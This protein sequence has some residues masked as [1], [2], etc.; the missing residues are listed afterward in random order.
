MRNWRELGE[1]P[2]SE[3][4][5]SSSDETNNDDLEEPELPEPEVAVAPAAPV[6]LPIETPGADADQDGTVDD[7]WD[8]PSSSPEFSRHH[9][10]SSIRKQPPPKPPPVEGQEEKAE[11]PIQNDSLEGEKSKIQNRDTTPQSSLSSLSSISSPPD[12]PILPQLSSSPTRWQPNP[13]PVQIPSTP[14]RLPSSHPP[15]PSSSPYPIPDAPRIPSSSPQPLEAPQ[16]T[17]VPEESP[18]RTAIRLE[19]S[20]RPRKPIQ[21]HP[22]LLENAKYATFMKSH[23]VKPIKVVQ[24]SQSTRETEEEDSQEQ[25]FQDEESQETP[26]V[27]FDNSDVDEL[28]LSPS[29]PKTSPGHNLRA[30]SQRTNGGSNTD[31]T[32]MSDGED[33]PDLHNLKPIS[34]KKRSRTLQSLKRPS[35]TQQL[36]S[37]RRKRPRVIPDD[38]SPIFPSRLAPPLITRSLPSSPLAREISQQDLETTRRSPTRRLSNTPSIAFF[39]VRRQETPIVIEDDESQDTPIFVQ[40]NKPEETPILQDDDHNESSDAESNPSGE[41][42]GSESEVV[43][44]HSRR[45]RGVLPASWL[46]L[47]QPAPK[48][49]VRQPRYTP[50][51]PEPIIR[52]GV[53]LPKPGTQRPPPSTAFLFDDSEESDGEPSGFQAASSTRP[54]STAPAT[55]ILID[56]DASSGMEDDMVDWMLPGRKRQSSNLTS[57]RSKKQKKTA[58][59]S[60]FKGR[61]GQ[62][63]RQ[64]KITSALSR[65]KSAATASTSRTR[66][67][68]KPRHSTTQSKRKRAVTPPLLS[69]LD[70]IEPDAPNFLKIAAR[71][72][73]KKKTMGK[74]SP[75][76]KIISLASRADNID[77]LSTLRAWKSGKTQPRVAPELSKRPTQPKKRPVMREVSKNVPSRAQPARPKQKTHS[78]ELLRQS[79]LESFVLVED[80]NDEV[81]QHSEA[82]PH[83]KPAIRKKPIQDR[84]PWMRPAQLEEDED[85]DKRRQLNA[86][87]RRL[88]AFYKRAQQVLNLPID[89][90]PRTRIDVDFTLQ[91]GSAHQNDA[92]TSLAPQ[93]STMTTRDKPRVAK[94]R[95]RKTRRPRHVDIE[96]PQ[97]LRANDPLPAEV[98]AV[99]V[100]D[101]KPDQPQDKLQGLGSYGTIYTQHF[102]V[103]PLDIGVFFHQS[104]VIGRGLV[105]KA[106][107]SS[108]TERLRHQ[109]A[110]VSWT[111]GEGVVFRWGVW[112][113][114]TSSELGILVDWIGEQ[115]S[116]T[117]A[118]SPMVGA[119]SPIEASDFI[120]CYILKS[121]SV[122]DELA[123]KAVVARCMEVFTSFTARFD[124]LEWKD[125]SVR[126]TT[127]RFE[128]ASRFNVAMLAV[129]SI[130]L[131]GSNPME[132]MKVE[133]V[134]T[135]LCRTTIK[136][137]LQSG[138]D[139]LREVY[140]D[141]QQ[142]SFRERGIRSDRVLVNCWVIVLRVLESVNIPRSS[143]W[144]VTQSVMLSNGA[145]SGL[146]MHT[147]EQLWQNMFTLLPLCEIDNAGILIPGLR[148]TAPM[149]GW[150]LP[151]RLL[152]RVFELYQRNPRQPASFNEYCRALVAR[153]HFLVQQWGWRKYTVILG[154]IFDFFGSQ[155]LANLRNE[156]VYKSPRFLEELGGGNPSLFIQPE[157]RC[158]HIFIKLLALAI[159]KL[160]ELGRVNDIK[161]LVARTLPNHNRQYHK[162]DTIHQHDLAALR[163]HHDLLCN[164]FWVSPP[165]LRP[166]VHL[167]EKLVVPASAHKEACLISIRAWS[168]LARFVISNGEGV[169][170]FRPFAVWRNNIFNQVLD[171]Y[172]SAE[173]DIEQQFRALAH[174]GFQGI[175]KEMRD[176]MIA[177]NKASALD[178]LA[179]SVKTS[180]VV[181]Q[182]APT[183]EA[184]MYGLNTTQLQKVFTS[185]DF[186]SQKFDWSILSVALDT[187]GNFVARIDQASEEQYSSEFLNNSQSVHSRTL[188]EAILMVNEQ[189]ARDFFW[190]SRTILSL[191]TPDS[192][193]EQNPQT[194]CVEKTITLA[195]KLA[196][197]FIKDRLTKL[198]S[199]FTPGKYS[200]F[201]SLPKDNLTGERKYLPLFLAHLLKNQIFDF[202]DIGTSLLGLWILSIIKPYSLLQYENFLGETLEHQNLPFI[203]SVSVIP[204]TSPDYTTNYH[205]FLSA[206]QYMRQ[207]LRSASSSTA[208]KSLREEYSSILTLCQTRIKSD[209]SSSLYSNTADY[210][211][212][213]QQLISLLKS[214]GVNIVTIDSFF[215]QP[216]RVYS[217]PMHDLTLH[218]AGIIAYGV[219]LSERDT[220]AGP[221][222]FWY[223][224]NSFKLAF[225]NGKLREEIK[226]LKKVLREEKNVRG[227]VMSKILPAV[228]MGVFMDGRGRGE[229][230]WLILEV[231]VWVLKGVL[232]EGIMPLE[233]RGE[234]EVEGIGLML[235]LVG[236]WLSRG[237][238]DLDENWVC[239]LAQVMEL[240]ELLRSN[241]VELMASSSEEIMKGVRA[242]EKGFEVFKKWA[243]PCDLDEEDEEDGRREA[244]EVEQVI[245]VSPE[246]QGYAKTIATD[247][248]NNWRVDRER[249]YIKMAGATTTTTGMGEVSV[250]YTRWDYG[251]VVDVAEM[252]IE[253][254][255]ESLGGKWRESLGGK[256]RKKRRREVDV[257]VEEGV[258]LIF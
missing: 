200:I 11:L 52:K 90:G 77:A 47:N 74:S 253:K 149:E 89:D 137:L 134:I 82:P 131:A 34:V 107:E 145:A 60:V 116:N 46:R 237:W 233:L 13:P 124:S 166:A 96:A 78:G 50:E 251:E 18:R 57:E 254:W 32:S 112:D 81:P 2:D 190:M 158:F 105:Q 35:S 103:F 68:N 66:G 127:K 20:L 43:R 197:R 151:Q 28:V 119:P 194:I 143:F 155:N 139:E 210:I 252:V 17:D 189:L 3:N 113:D 249:I 240:V 108:F 104:T 215:L 79:N 244:E 69:I 214:H 39:D 235:R 230:G 106:L 1:V 239:L 217:P 54:P 122:A 126:S 157:D 53:A 41:S 132:T 6:D 22:Y 75:S 172:L 110:S 193:F 165:D 160:K 228:L 31:A 63:L 223:L 129:R 234:E 24:A 33:L 140:G 123:E 255:R 205:F 185:L 76:R 125:T 144:D 88:D 192:F 8:I 117:E 49:P 163:N 38:S 220:S 93:D 191:P 170:A 199:Y 258:D 121:L 176:D 224:W 73:K 136:H 86:R 256:G 152:K 118:E 84:G 187:F 250:E 102:D 133:D 87:K 174:E 198:S 138:L 91:R 181:L 67:I 23:G 180:L 7:I 115:L 92:Q 177:K 175:S 30:S 36:S 27:L 5:D 211:K 232:R 128:V 179:L 59:Q 65:S 51:P 154:T 10:T 225:G 100:E 186:H 242:L 98:F 188:E 26:P 40:D 201:S 12:S 257:G 55:T 168:Q 209:L 221:Q 141:L 37:A 161:N 150:T 61:P 101:P 94:S 173:S 95:Y 111:S 72:A 147:F 182:K 241:V 146:N 45:I 164:L 56:D 171:Q 135:K 142:S 15:V 204:P 213:I 120:L 29:L 236:G 58:T 169:D 227:F 178:V 148:K 19:R 238:D 208:R 229:Q 16:I 44:E 162:E 184:A 226:I 114:K 80:E 109:K 14:P 9:P 222:L 203:Q 70:V 130:S 216:S 85:E 4:D 207:S 167:I 62:T 83:P 99:N 153:C 195:A 245:A 247:V 97:Y 64:P 246:I 206:L 219:R 21:Q 218:A 196:S 25:E 231:W 243:F 212:F 248:G 71:T 202:R 156:E 48:A 42:S 183:L 159:K